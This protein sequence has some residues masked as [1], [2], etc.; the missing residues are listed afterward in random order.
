MG[1]LER[2]IHANYTEREKGEEGKRAA[3]DITI[4]GLIELWILVK[5]SKNVTMLYIQ[6]ITIRCEKLNHT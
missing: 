2:S 6:A 1:Y 3:D 5:A 4:F